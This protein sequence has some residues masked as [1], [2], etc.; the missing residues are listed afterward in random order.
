RP[1]RDYRAT[2][3]EEVPVRVEAR[4]DFR[5]DALELHYSVNGGEWRHE[6]L[7]A[8]TADIQAAAMLRLEELQQPGADGSVPVL[9]PGDLVSYYAEARDNKHSVQTDLF[10]IQVQPFEQRYTQLQAG[11]GGGG[12]G[13]GE[14]EQDGE[15]SR[16]QREILVATWN[17]QR[18]QQEAG[19]RE[20][21]RAAD[22]ARM[23]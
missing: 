20:K 18:S 1:G 22:N 3:I 5:L 9:V 15:I 12:G 21:E 7:P 19:Q 10:L 8:G 11:G 16:R 13:D 14:G 4:D 17:L 23:L 6:R 2:A